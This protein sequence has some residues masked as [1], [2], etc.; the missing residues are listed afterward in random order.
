MNLLQKRMLVVMASSRTVFRCLFLFVLV[1]A[2]AAVTTAQFSAR[3]A[4]PNLTFNGPVVVCTP[5]D[6]TNRMFVVTQQGTIYE[7][8]NDSNTTT[9]NIFLDKSDSVVSGGELGMLGLVFHPQYKTN[10]YFY[11]Y[12]TVTNHVT[13][14]PYASILSRF[15]VSPTNPDSGLRS[16][17]TVLLRV[18]QPFPN[19]KG[20]QLA[21]GPDGYLY[22]GLGDGGSGGDPY[23]NG[24]NTSS[25]LGKMLRIDVNTPSGGLQ[26]SIPPGNPF[27]NDTSSTI[28]KEIFAYGFRN[29]WRYSFD[30]VTNALWVGDVGQ[31]L[32]E[33]VDTVLIGRNYG[34][35][36]MEGF[37]CYNYAT[38]DSTGLTPPLVEYPHV[39]GQCAIIGGYVYRGSAIP[40]LYGKYIFGDY[41]AGRV[42]TMDSRNPG[43]ATDSVLLETG[44]QLSAFGIDQYRELYLCDYANGIVLKFFTQAPGVPLPAYPLNTAAGIHLRP[45]IGWLKDYNAGAY[46]LQVASD[47]L[48]TS[49]VESDSITGDTSYLAVPLAF[50]TKYYWS[51]RASNGGG[52]SAYSAMSSFTTLDSIPP[53]PPI[54]LS[55]ANGAGNQAWI[56]HLRWSSSLSALTYGCQLALDSL[57][58]TILTADLSLSDTTLQVGSLDPDT[59]YYWRARATNEAGNGAY[60]SYSKFVTASNSVIV[61]LQNRWNMVSLPAFAEDSHAATIFP[62]AVSQM[63][64]YSAGSGYTP[65]D[66][67]A[68][69]NGYWI[70]YP[71]TQTVAIAGFP[72][73]S[74]SSALSAGW[75]MVG[76]LGVPLATTMIQSNPP[77]LVTSQFFGYAGRYISADTLYPG[78][79][80]WVKATQ[81]GT[82]L[83]SSGSSSKSANRIRVVPTSEKPPAPPGDSPNGLVVVPQSY[84]LDQNYPNPFNPT[85][86]FRYA[87]PK[88]SYVRLRVYN[89]L[90]ELVGTLADGNQTAGYKQVSWNGSTV[91]SGVYFYRLDAVSNSDG[92]VVFTRIRKMAMI[93]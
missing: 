72:R 34:W 21:F 51:V 33:E 70:K 88:D 73:L 86:T 80:Y 42:W 45:R 83:F 57:F 81:S 74:D 91:A 16:S 47:S 26:Y 71:D 20:G 31:D 59:T 3:N 49:I 75:N 84:A 53:N 92:Y 60:S 17:E 79:G 82:L 40:G 35:H 29:P 90:G 69:G 10:G 85:T 41:C 39:N 5:P 68:V 37:H 27:A 48:F 54:L 22:L 8:P 13:G 77:A 36:I 44:T 65:A 24:Q 46:R 9:T 14:Y 19:H 43:F 1:L 52:T 6:S 64:A 76:A 4:F 18:N 38:C 32:Y 93:K 7:F 15:S 2:A 56:V 12:Y 78:F 25:F 11:V 55:P 23:G 62:D 30:P 61:H 89:V 28:K 87:L 63:F 58:T 66:T 67:L 50:S